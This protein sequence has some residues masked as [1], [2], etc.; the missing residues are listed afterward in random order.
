MNV[1]RHVKAW[2]HHA[3]LNFGVFLFELKKLAIFFAA[4]GFFFI[5]PPPQLH[6]K[7]DQIEN[8]AKGSTKDWFKYG[9]DSN[10]KEPS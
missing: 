4:K 10:S 5:F 9:Y 2:V 7:K 1:S 6:H 8:L 3:A